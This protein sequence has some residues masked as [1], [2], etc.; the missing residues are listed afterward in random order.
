M[1]NSEVLLEELHTILHGTL[2]GML[3]EAIHE[4]RDQREHFRKLAADSKPT[5]CW[6]STESDPSETL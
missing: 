1:P 3:D 2:R 5:A 4:L 6:A